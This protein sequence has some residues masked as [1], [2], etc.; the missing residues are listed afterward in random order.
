VADHHIDEFEYD[1]LE[2]QTDF[3]YFNDLRYPVG[4][5]VCSGDRLLCC[6]KGG[7]WVPKGPCHE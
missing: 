7:V 6:E 4:D 1:D 2:M 5:Y 3:C